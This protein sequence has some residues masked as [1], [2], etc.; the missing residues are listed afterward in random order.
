[1]PSTDVPAPARRAIVRDAIGIGVATGAFGLSYGAIAVASGLSVLQ[2]VA[3]SLLMF[4]GASQFALAGVVG[5]GGGAF[6]SAATAV[7][8][9]TRN[10]LYGLQLSSLL[11]TIGPRRLLAAQLVIDESAAMA[12][13]QDDPPRA[14]VGF[15]ATGVS[16][17]VLWNLGSLIGAVGAGLLEDPDRFGLDVAGPAAF[18]ALLAPRL[19]DRPAWAVAA[20]AAVAALVSVPFVPAGMPVLVAAGVAAVATFTRP[21]A[22]PPAAATSPDRE[23]G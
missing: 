10:A 1:M 3:L 19:R 13:A 21:P 14:R 8:L 20:L 7:L 23:V 6:A 2:T 15:W 11:R 4:T 16:V 17:F 22:T 18:V 5:A 9:G 12:V